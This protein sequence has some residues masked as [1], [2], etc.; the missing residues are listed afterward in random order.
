VFKRQ[1]RLAAHALLLVALVAL[2]LGSEAASASVASTHDGAQQDNALVRVTFLSPV[3][4]LYHPEGITVGGLKAH[5]AEVRLLGAIDR[6]GLAYE[7]TP[8]PW[9]HLR[10]LHGSWHGL[11]TPPPLLGIYQLQLRIDGH[12]L[13]T[14]PNWLL[15]VFQPG[16]RSR[17]PYPTATAAVRGYVTQ[18]AGS[19]HLV[20]IKQWPLAPF[21]HRNPRLH[22]LF[23]IAYAPSGDQRTDSRRGMFITT[24][25]DGFHG[26]W[27]LLDATT[28]PYG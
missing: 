25:R 23:V 21:D 17:Q 28:Q 22:R 12:A 6:R 3:I 5:G 18:L 20:A 9:R 26:R 8:Y 7:W 10:L 2:T 14:S 27:R 4:D 13:L 24:V 15:R 16:T 1:R 11:L 19:Q